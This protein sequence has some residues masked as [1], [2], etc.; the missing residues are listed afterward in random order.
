MIKNSLIWLLLIAL[1]VLSF[2]L[3]DASSL[4][5]V[6]AV[7]LAVTAVKGWFIVDGFMELNGVNH[8]L[9]TGMLLYC[10]VVGSIILYVL[11]R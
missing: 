1:T 10:P 3:T 8:L 5:W 2:F 11:I 7:I 9:R 4:A 6:V